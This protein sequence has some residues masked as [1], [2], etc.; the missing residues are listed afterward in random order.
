MYIYI[1]MKMKVNQETVNQES[2]EKV[3]GEQDRTR[4][5]VSDFVHEKILIFFT[6]P[7]SPASGARPKDSVNMERSTM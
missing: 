4:S 3:L 7:P 6:K 2:I 5:R 1:Y